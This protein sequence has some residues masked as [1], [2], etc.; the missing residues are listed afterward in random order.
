MTSNFALNNLLTY[1]DMRLKGWQWCRG[2]VSFMLV[3]GVGTLANVSMA[4]SLFDRGHFWLFSALAGIIV[5]AVWNYAVSG[6]YTWKK[7]RRPHRLGTR[8]AAPVWQ[9]AKAL[10]AAPPEV[11]S[12]R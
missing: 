11:A 2:W 9:G 12:E 6:T 1:R 3:C 4:S 8:L 7:P 5:G 10:F